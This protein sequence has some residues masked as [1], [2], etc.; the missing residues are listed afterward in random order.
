[1]TGA[2][3]NHPNRYHFD[4]R[5]RPIA[6]HRTRFRGFQ[7]VFENKQA[8]ESMLRTIDDFPHLPIVATD[9]PRIIDAGANIGIS[10]LEWKYRW[11]TC[12]II[13]FEPD[14]FAFALLKE[15]MECNDIP[16]VECVQAAVS[17]TSGRVALHGSI[18][19]GT[20]GRGN[21]IL[22][23]W[24]KRP[25]ST[26]TDVACIR[27]APYL[28]NE[29]IAFLKMDIEGMEER[30]LLDCSPYL[31]S[32]ESAYVEVHE[33]LELETVN[34]LTRIEKI[35]G[36]AGFQIDREARFGPH[37]FPQDLRSWQRRVAAKQWQLSCWRDSSVRR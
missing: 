36:D 37:A 17:D 9:A 20:D 30:V 18:G 8:T 23:S 14:P 21:S 5:N 15:N 4:P 2:A 10:V 28:I 19:R 35:L 26:S 6:T 32:I 24:G 13:C 27:L 1:M 16:G 7:L 22:P 25:T 11:P 31:S 12:R 29:P 34:S 33:T 3:I